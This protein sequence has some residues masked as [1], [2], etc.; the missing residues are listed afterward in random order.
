MSNLKSLINSYQDELT[1]HPHL[2]TFENILQ[3]FHEKRG[4]KYVSIRWVRDYRGQVVISNAKV[5]NDLWGGS[6]N[7]IVF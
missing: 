7:E 4:E 5:C 3:H 6:R 1:I 2:E